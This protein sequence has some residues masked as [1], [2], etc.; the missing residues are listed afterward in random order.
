MKKVFLLSLYISAQ[1]LGLSAPSFADNT[2]AVSSEAVTEHYVVM[3]H[4]MF[5]EA[6]TAASE[7]AVSTDALLA[8]PNKVNHLKAKEAWVAAHRA[9]S[10]TE[11]FRFGNPNVD[12]WEGQVN[13]WPMDEGLVDYVASGYVSDSGNPFAQKNLIAD[14]VSIDQALLRNMHE[15]AGSEANVATGYHVIEFL[16]WG[17]DLNTTKNTAGIRSHL[18]FSLSQCATVH[19][20]R[21]A[22]YMQE[23]VDLLLSDLADMV[24]QWQPAQGDYAKTFMALDVDTRLQRML[25]GLGSLAYAELAGERIRV[26]ML[27]QSQ[28]DE[29]SCFSDMTHFAIKENVDA[30]ADVFNGVI[31]AGGQRSTGPSLGDLLEKNDTV[32][33]SALMLAFTKA[34]RTVDKVVQQAKNGLPFDQQIL[35][36]NVAAYST[37]EMLIAQLREQA[38]LI[39]SINSLQLAMAKVER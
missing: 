33:H 35:L 29:Q 25:L 3:A 39:E 13:A 8:S 4:A 9:Y 30:V 19:C 38:V 22:L 11:V 12:D 28:E 10:R 17:Q 14:S 16:L 18:D 24:Q 34:Q 37:L 21:R 7:L 6:Q 2:P 5:K 32:K 27:A 20:D 23:S 36:D 1:V 31:Q 26:A 15:G